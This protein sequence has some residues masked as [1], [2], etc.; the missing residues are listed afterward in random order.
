MF[1]VFLF[2]ILGAIALFVTVYAV[3]AFS[4]FVAY[5]ITAF[6]ISK[7]RKGGRK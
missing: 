6:K 4:V 7:R 1:D 5:V 3:M 2:I